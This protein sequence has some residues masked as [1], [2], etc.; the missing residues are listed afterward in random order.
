MNPNRVFPA[1]TEKCLGSL[2][3]KKSSAGNAP[4]RPRT[5]DEISLGAFSIP[6]LE[7]SAS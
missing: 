2:W 4:V 1:A 6:G 7:L 5:S 3:V